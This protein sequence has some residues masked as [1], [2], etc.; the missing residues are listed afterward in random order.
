MMAA[1]FWATQKV[2]ADYLHAPVILQT[3]V[4][5]ES[6]LMPGAEPGHW[7]QLLRKAQVWNTLTT[8]REQKDFGAAT[9]TFWDCF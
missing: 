5:E 7:Y 9:A 3:V 6:P 2:T 8:H 4:G 1:A